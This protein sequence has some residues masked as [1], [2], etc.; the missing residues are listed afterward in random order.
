M[1]LF[2]SPRLTTNITH[3]VYQFNS[4]VIAVSCQLPHDGSFGSGGDDS[5]SRPYRPSPLLLQ[6]HKKTATQVLF[7]GDRSVPVAAETAVYDR[8]VA[9]LFNLC[10]KPP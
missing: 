1:K 3:V 6:R 7:S 10:A 4:V 8:S 9:S 2:I 5:S